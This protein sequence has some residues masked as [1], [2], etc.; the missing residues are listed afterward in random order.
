M[1]AR[2][3]E[4]LGPLADFDD[5]GKAVPIED[6]VDCLKRE[7]T[8]RIQVYPKWVESGRYTE[9]RAKLELKRMKACLQTIVNLKAEIDRQM[10]VE[11]DTN[12]LFTM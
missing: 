6:Q 7:L 10:G 9:K 4:L 8:M 2:V 12:T 3:K 1:D 5:D 11:T